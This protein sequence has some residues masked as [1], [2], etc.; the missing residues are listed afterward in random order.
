MRMF[1]LFLLLLCNR[2]LCVYVNACV[3]CFGVCV[4]VCV[5]VCACVRVRERESEWVYVLLLV[6]FFCRG[7]FVSIQW[8]FKHE[9]GFYFKCHQD[10]CM[11]VLL[12]LFTA[13]PFRFCCMQCRI[14]YE[15]CGEPCICLSHC[16]PF[17]FTQYYAT[18]VLVLLQHK[19][20]PY[21]LTAIS[22]MLMVLNSQTP[23]VTW[24]F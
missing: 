13:K 7:P 3:Y 10:A 12:L 5:C 23:D 19:S 1:Q 24:F 4:C 11:H 9:N 8:P 16:H 21:V 20:W 15:L 18:N 14:A 17:C 6:L 22:I 2:T